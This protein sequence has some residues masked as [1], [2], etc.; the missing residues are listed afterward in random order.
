MRVSRCGFY[1]EEA[2]AGGVEHEVFAADLHAAWR[3]TGH[4][5]AER[6]REHVL[7]SE[8]P[9]QFEALLDDLLV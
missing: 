5:G 4:Y 6:K 1:W 9:F 8:C 7:V 2:R 3:R